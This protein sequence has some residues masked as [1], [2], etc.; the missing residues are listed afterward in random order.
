MLERFECIVID[1]NIIA[2]FC[3]SDIE[4]EGAVFCNRFWKISLYLKGNIYKTSNYK[5][6]IFDSPQLDRISFKGWNW[7]EEEIQYNH[8]TL[9]PHEP[10]SL[11]LI[12]Y[13]PLLL[14][15]S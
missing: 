13:L 2:S 12:L 4:Y 14:C 6:P 11:E 3:Y 7:L 8:N 1:L 10:P 5:P 9:V 15:C